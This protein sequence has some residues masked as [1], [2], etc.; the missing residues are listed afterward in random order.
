MSY[1]TPKHYAFRVLFNPYFT[2]LG[3]VPFKNKLYY[4][5]GDNAL[6]EVLRPLVHYLNY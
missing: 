5:M 2:I 6:L 3:P 1:N 4:L